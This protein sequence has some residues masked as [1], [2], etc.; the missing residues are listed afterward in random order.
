MT[1]HV[2]PPNLLTRFGVDGADSAIQA[3]GIQHVRSNRDS[4]GHPAYHAVCPDGAILYG[5]R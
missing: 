1:A 2:T 5:R 3:A 4:Y